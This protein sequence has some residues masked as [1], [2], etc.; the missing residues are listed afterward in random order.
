MS[1]S[2]TNKRIQQMQKVQSEGLELFKKKNADYGDSFANYGPVGVIVRTGDKINRLSSVTQNGVNLVDTE[3]VRDTLID[4]HNYAAMAIMLLDEKKQ[5]QHRRIDEI[6]N[7][8]PINE[9]VTP[10]VSKSQPTPFSER[11]KYRW[12]TAYLTKQDKMAEWSKQ[13]KSSES[14]R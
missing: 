2:P 13:A 8:R 1:L 11:R 3:S 9:I 7:A 6:K 10:F 12:A 4:L 5:I 14:R